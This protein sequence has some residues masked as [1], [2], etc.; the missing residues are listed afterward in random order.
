MSH[1]KLWKANVQHTPNSKKVVLYNE[2]L[3]RNITK[4]YKKSTPSTAQKI[5]EEDRMITEQLEISDRVDTTAYKEAFITLI[6]RILPINQYVDSSTLP[7]LKLAK[8]VNRSWIE[9]TP[10]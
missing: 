10:E 7:N 2:L 4:S 6:S 3:E 9:S 1:Q 8:S 5:R